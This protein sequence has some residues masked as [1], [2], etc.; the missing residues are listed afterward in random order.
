MIRRL[1]IIAALALASLPALA[2]EP[3]E[4]LKD[5]KL[6]AR[7]RALSQ[8]LRCLVCE[9]ETIDMSQAP[10][11][12]DLRL[13]VRQRILAGDS[14][15]QIRKLLT[16]RY[17]EYVLFRPRFD[18]RNAVLWIGPFA[19]LLLVGYVLV[20][21]SRGAVPNTQDALTA[22]EEMELAADV[23]DSGTSDATPNAETSPA[24]RVT[25]I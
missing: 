17:G 20:M 21:R 1:L 19:L 8:E 7:A 25:K 10:L 22:A 11:A 12:A 24:P 5:P 4:Q 16:D 23:S 13:L 2:I 15:A 3:E 9:N 18:A 6:E 14:D